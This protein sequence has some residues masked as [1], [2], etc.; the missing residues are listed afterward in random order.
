MDLTEMFHI[1]FWILIIVIRDYQ[2][3]GLKIPIMTLRWKEIFRQGNIYSVMGNWYVRVLDEDDSK[4]Y[5][6][7]LYIDRDMCRR[8]PVLYQYTC[9]W[10]GLFWRLRFVQNDDV[11]GTGQK[12]WRTIK[13]NRERLS[14]WWFDP[15]GI[16]R[17]RWEAKDRMRLG[18]RSKV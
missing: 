11:W 10:N 9:L 8:D 6:L 13:K 17:Y 3:R 4:G 14:L 5:T 16:Q 12:P 7:D 18:H 15:A 2:S 1:I